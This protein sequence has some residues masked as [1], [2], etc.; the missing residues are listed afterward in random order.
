M[1]YLC[2]LKSLP[3]KNMLITKRPR[4]AAMGI[5][6]KITL[7]KAVCIINAGAS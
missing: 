1:E 4:V 3:L 6:G 7:A 5:L 2:C